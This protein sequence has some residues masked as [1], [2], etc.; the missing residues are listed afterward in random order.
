MVFLL[1]DLQRI[2][3][4][5]EGINF[6]QGKAIREMLGSLRDTRKSLEATNA[7]RGSYKQ[8]LNRMGILSK[9]MIRENDGNIK[10]EYLKSILEEIWDHLDCVLNFLG[11][12]KR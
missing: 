11:D 2:F 6:S 5:R 4:E 3:I 7:V 10:D 12:T 9:N 8:M 1:D